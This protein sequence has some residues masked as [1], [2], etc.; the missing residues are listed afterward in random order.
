MEPIGAVI[1][2]DIIRSSKY[3]IEQRKEIRNTINQAV[4]TLSQY[5]D[6]QKALPFP[7]HIY[8]GDSWQVLVTKPAL[9]FRTA[10]YIRAS[11]RADLPSIKANTRMS[12]S[13]GQIHK[14]SQAMSFGDGEAYIL[15]GRGLDEISQKSK[16]QISFSMSD[17]ISGSQGIEAAISAMLPALDFISSSWTNKQAQVIQLVLLGRKLEDIAATWPGGAI[18]HRAVEIHLDRSGWKAVEA[19]IVQMESL[20][21]KY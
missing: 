9:A 16:S 21:E 2:G 1:T 14:T 20:V 19:A 6:F 12:L 18:Q 10:I 11:L 13:I 3:T 7:V 4:K 5:E 15:S 8:R 17:Q